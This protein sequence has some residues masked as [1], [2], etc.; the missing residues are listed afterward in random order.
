M[1]RR[2]S[3]TQAHRDRT[4]EL[5]AALDAL[6]AV[7]IE[8]MGTARFRGGEHKVITRATLDDLIAGANRVRGVLDSIGECRAGRSERMGFPVVCDQCAHLSAVWMTW[9]RHKL[10]EHL[11]PW[12][13]DEPHKALT[14]AR[15]PGAW[16]ENY[17]KEWQYWADRLSTAG[18][19]PPRRGA[20]PR[21]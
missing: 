9:R 21:G 6:D 18:T 8:Y 15:N 13:T 17:V 1:R 3:P 16:P 20:R 10:I 11:E 2:E 19:A 7:P 12:V 4:G 14:H 5:R